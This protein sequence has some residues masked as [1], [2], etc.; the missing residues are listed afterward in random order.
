MSAADAA[1]AAVTATLVASSTSQTA[2]FQV[3]LDPT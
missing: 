3:T 2:V 1:T